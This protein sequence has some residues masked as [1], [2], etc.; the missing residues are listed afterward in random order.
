M[1]ALASLEELQ[2]VSARLEQLKA[3]HPEAYNAFAELLKAFRKVGYKN[4]CKL[5]LGESTPE[6]LKGEQ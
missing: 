4:I 5:L 3:E 6:K 2:K 1:P